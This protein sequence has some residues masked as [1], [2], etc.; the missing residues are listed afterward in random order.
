[1]QSI[2]PHFSKIAKIIKAD[3]ESGKNKIKIAVA[4]F[5]ND[6][7]FN[8]LLKKLDNSEIKIELILHD[9]PINNNQFG[10]DWSLFIS[11]GGTLYINNNIEKMHHKFYIIDDKIIS[12]GSYNWTKSAEKYNHENIIRAKNNIYLINQYTKEFNKLKHE[13]KSS[14]KIFKK[15]LLALLSLSD[16]GLHKMLLS[17]EKLHLAKKLID[18]GKYS[19][20]NTLLNSAFK[21]DPT[22]EI[23]RLII[24]TE[25]KCNE[26]EKVKEIEVSSSWNSVEYYNEAMKVYSEVNLPGNS[27]NEPLRGIIGGSVVLAQTNNEKHNTDN[28]SNKYKFA[29]YSQLGFEKIISLNSLVN[30]LILKPTLEIHNIILTSHKIDSSIG[31]YSVKGKFI[32]TSSSDI[33]FNI[34]KGQI[35]ENKNHETETQN[36]AIDKEYNFKLSSEEEI[37]FNLGAFCMNGDLPSPQNASGR[38]TV[39]KISNPNKWNNQDE[40]WQYLTLLAEKNQKA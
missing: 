23:K 14:V 9:D 39:F 26:H 3:I 33:Q 30:M 17:F 21:N 25:E 15:P 28:S 22:D 37:D 4:W 19:Y 6:D 18:N 16:N 12:T 13:I 40:L 31:G 38:I 24:E 36:L 5:T 8:I 34:P 20:A 29:N 10:I 1:M 7:L 11:K 35:F 2:E 27:I 32:N